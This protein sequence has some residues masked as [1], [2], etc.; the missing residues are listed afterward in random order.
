MGKASLQ[1]YA[2]HVF[3]SFVRWERKWKCLAVV[4]YQDVL[5]SPMLLL[6]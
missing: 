2:V 6:Y 4:E 3:S 1:E 5:T